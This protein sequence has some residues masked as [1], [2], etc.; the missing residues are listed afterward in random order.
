MKPSEIIEK[1]VEATPYDYLT[2]CGANNCECYNNSV[3]IEA[4]IKLLDSKML[5]FDKDGIANTTTSGSTG[6]TSCSGGA[7]CASENC[8]DHHG[9]EII[10]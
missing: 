7:L 8:V 10:K 2:P 3:K 6:P 5:I 4:I 1:I 9:I